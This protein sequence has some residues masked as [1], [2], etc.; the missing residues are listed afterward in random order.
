MAGKVRNMI[1]RAGRFHARLVVPKD[2]RQIVGKT[3][4]RAPLGGDYRTAL[5]MLPGAVAQ[6][7]H[8]IALAERKAGHVTRLAPRY[9]LAP[10]QIAASH[11]AQ[12]LAFDDR[13]RN[14]PRYPS[15]GIDD[16]LVSRLRE[17]IA[18]KAND[19]ELAALAGSQIERFRAT[20]NVDAAQGSD[21]WRGIARVLCSAELEALARV[22][23]RDEGDFTGTPT[24]PL[25]VNAQPPQDTPAPVSLTKLWREYVDTRTKAGFMRGGSRRQDPV[26]ENLRKFVKHDDA[27]RISKADV[28]AWREHLMKTLSA[29][30]V[31]DI[32][33]STIRTLFAWA[34]END[35][36]SAN[37]AAKVRQAKPRR[38]YSREK[39]FTEAEAVKVLQV[40]TTYTASADVHGYI[41]E[42]THLVAAKRWVPIIC[43]FSG[44]RVSEITQLRKE[45]VREVDGRWIIRITP[46]AGSV[47]AGDYRDVPL[48]AQIVNL[49]FP[50]FV[51][52]AKSGPLFHGGT[53]PEKYAAKA[54]RISNQIGDWLGRLEL[55]P[56]D[57]RPNYGWRHRFKTQCRDLGISDRVAD[58]IQGHAGRTASDGYGD[59]TIKARITA[60]DRLPKY[61]LL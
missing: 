30:T 23:E 19:E 28:M 31:S 21:E 51:Q 26:I 4:L 54:R 34:E 25:I 13:L 29:K 42:K 1:N 49:G 52:S 16:L 18:G 32:Y 59:V 57:V 7:Q 48:H 3:E 20:G 36:L 33:L 60:I 5:K 6:L 2:L 58:A 11:Y 35:R 43:A 50:E 14:D 8:K 22:A 45:D 61:D 10:D 55:V 12:R 17:A 53:E 9:P 24:T 37:V 15:V 39:G 44:A 47:K 40:A 27:G 41:R 38:Q 56:D 46:D